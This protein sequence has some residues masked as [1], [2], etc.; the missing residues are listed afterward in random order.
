MLYDIIEEYECLI[1]KIE[2][3]L[4]TN[5]AYTNE[6]LEEITNDKRERFSL[7]DG[8]ELLNEQIVK[9]LKT[10]SLKLTNVMKD[11]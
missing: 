2:Y 4:K 10:I 5:K 8:M 1:L 3:L 7:I 6:L 9:E 11:N